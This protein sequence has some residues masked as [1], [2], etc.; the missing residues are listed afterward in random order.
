MIFE[1]ML[2]SGMGMNPQRMSQRQYD[3]M[4]AKF[5]AGMQREEE[6][7]REPSSAPPPTWQAAPTPPKTTD[8]RVKELYRL[9]VRRLHPDMRADGDTEV[10]AIWHDV[11]EAYRTGNVE[12]LEMLLALSELEAEAFGDGTSV[13]QMR[14]VLAELRRSYNALQRN[15]KAAQLDPAWNFAHRQDRAMLEKRMTR[16]LQRNITDLEKHLQALEAQIAKWASPRGDRRR[17][18]QSGRQM[19][20]F[21]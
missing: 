17:N 3:S 19:D 6:H 13:S 16:D 4:F 5:K 9:L 8:A 11:Q 21:G 12:R 2:I 18:D 15:L 1:E 14:S 20:L 7:A 10:S